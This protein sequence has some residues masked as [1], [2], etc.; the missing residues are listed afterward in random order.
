MHTT[1]S[2][3]CGWVSVA[4][5]VFSSCNKRGPLSRHD[6]QASHCDAPLLAEHWL[7]VHVLQ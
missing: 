4:A 2:F 1:Y 6:A 5:G 3:V 7:Q